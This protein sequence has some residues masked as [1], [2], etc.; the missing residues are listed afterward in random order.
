MMRRLFFLLP[1]NRQAGQLAVDLEQ[2]IA[3]NQQHINAVAR[4]NVSIGVIRKQ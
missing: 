3:I 1:N 2:D 4:D